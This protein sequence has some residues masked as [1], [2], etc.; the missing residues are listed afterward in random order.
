MKTKYLKIVLLMIVAIAIGAPPC[1][2]KVDGYFFVVAYSYRDKAVYCSAIFTDKVRKTSYSDDEYVT[3]VEIL[4]KIESAFSD[5]MAR[6]VQVD[7]NLYT[8]SSRGA[9]KSPSIALKYLEAE[10]KEHGKKGLAIKDVKTFKY[11]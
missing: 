11:K 1:F 2:A 9:F 8:L 3:E 6:V 7:M 10:K 4:Q 5:Y